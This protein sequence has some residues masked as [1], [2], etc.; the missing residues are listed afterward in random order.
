MTNIISP[1]PELLSN[2]GFVV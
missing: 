2:E 1:H